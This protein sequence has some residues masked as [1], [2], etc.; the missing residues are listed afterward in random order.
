MARRRYGNNSYYEN[1]APYVSSAQRLNDSDRKIAALRKQGKTLD[2]VRLEGTTIAR[3]FWGK[4]W[5]K[6]L[7]AY[8]DAANRL[9]RGRSYVRSGAVIDLQIAKGR[10]TAMVNGSR[11]YTVSIGIRKL[12]PERWSGIVESCAAAIGSLVELLQGRFPE[13][14]MQTITSKERGVFP[15][16]RQITMDCS[17]PD[18]A[19]MCKHVAAVLYG[20]GARLDRN[21]ELFFVLR[22]VD[23]TELI[24]AAG[25]GAATAIARNAKPRKVLKSNDL[26]AIFG[27]D[28]AVDEAT[29]D[30]GSASA[31]SVARTTSAAKKTRT[32]KKAPRAKK[33]PV[34]KK[35]PAPRG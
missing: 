12:E 25:A 27:I 13:S 16:P 14:V 7:E 15:A 10:V 9:P 34:P 31:P 20:V 26:S 21:P 28:I 3:T 4:A 1:F 35:K 2:P 5:C 11:L 23:H 29:P 8:S 33:K 6:N 18:G 22:N 19:T 32:A 24:A 30:T 17:C